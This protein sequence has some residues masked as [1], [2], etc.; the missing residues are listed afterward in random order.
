[1]LGGI[2]RWLD[3]AQSYII[4][5][6]A[7]SSRY[8]YASH[9]KNFDS[10]IRSVGLVPYPTTFE[11]ILAFITIRARSVSYKSIDLDLSAIC[12]AHKFL[13]L[14]IDVMEGNSILLAMKGIRR[15]QGNKNSQTQPTSTKELRKT[16]RLIL[17]SF[18]GVTFWATLMIVWNC[19]LRKAVLRDL[20]WA[21][22][23]QRKIVVVAQKSKT[24]QFWQGASVPVL[25]PCNI[26]A[27]NESICAVCAT[28]KLYRYCKGKAGGNAFP[29]TYK[30]NI[31]N[32]TIFF[33]K[34]GCK[35][36]LFETH[37]CRRGGA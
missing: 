35:S 25:C 1:M 19:L 31:Q 12:T 21:D 9:L 32:L 2:D 20:S 22:T 33:G 7:P 13:G 11:G 27:G 36:S 6:C 4:Q 24:D 14:P 17:M 16:K 15:S 29:F 34:V 37:S 30:E 5:A 18:E 28:A 3:D 8:Q 10:F 23:M 26:P